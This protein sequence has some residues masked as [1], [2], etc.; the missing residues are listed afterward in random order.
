MCSA[1]LLIFA[2]SLRST[3]HRVTLPPN[4]AEIIAKDETNPLHV[5]ESR[6]SIPY[7]LGPDPDSVIECLPTCTGPDRPPRYSPITQRAYNDMRASLVYP[8]KAKKKEAEEA[9]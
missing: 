5:L 8:A 2:A 4:A 1:C 3:K 6:Y 7:F 9:H